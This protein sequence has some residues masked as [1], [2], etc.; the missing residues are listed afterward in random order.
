MAKKLV[1]G[2]YAQE[3]AVINPTLE[4][5]QFFASVV[6][7][8]AE[9]GTVDVIVV[10]P[11]IKEISLTFQVKA[12]RDA[13]FTKF[14]GVIYEEGYPLASANKLRSSPLTSEVV[15]LLEPT[16]SNPGL[17]L[18]TWHL[19]FGDNIIG[20]E[21]EENVSFV[22]RNSTAYLFRVANLAP[23]SN[24]IS[25]RFAWSEADIIPT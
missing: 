10:A 24:W 22:L 2:Q 11:V 8:V 25:F 4:G 12:G 21:I 18:F 16:V 19:G 23:G 1:S 13:M 20:S 14:E 7:N 3:V 17:Q 6:F 5:D 15:I 9:E